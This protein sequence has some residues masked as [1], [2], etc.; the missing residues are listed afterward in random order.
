MGVISMIFYT[1]QPRLT[2]Y[3]HTRPDNRDNLIVDEIGEDFSDVWGWIVGTVILANKTR[4]KHTIY[5]YHSS[6]Y[7]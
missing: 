6:T 2:L 4:V 5:I 1:L 7:D 3:S